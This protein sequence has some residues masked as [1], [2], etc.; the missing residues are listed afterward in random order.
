MKLTYN[1]DFLYTARTMAEDVAKYSILS[2]FADTEHSKQ[3]WFEKMI[4]TASKLSFEL[5][6]FEMDQDLSNPD[7]LSEMIK[8]NELRH[9]ND[10]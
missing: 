5:S 3:H 7:L 10:A 8:E 6:V 2:R 4:E 1:E 9:T